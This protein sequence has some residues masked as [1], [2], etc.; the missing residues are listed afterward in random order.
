V[1]GDLIVSVGRADLVVYQ[2]VTVVGFPY[3]LGLERKSVL[4][5]ALSEQV[6]RGSLVN[7]RN[8]TERC[9]T[10]GCSYSDIRYKNK[11]NSI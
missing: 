3:I 2:I 6:G 4:C 10:R 1:N 7:G 11:H 9:D 8:T 5:C